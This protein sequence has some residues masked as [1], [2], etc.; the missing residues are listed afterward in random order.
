MSRS[1]RITSFTTAMVLTVM[2]GYGV[3]EL[4]RYY[5]ARTVYLPR[6]Q[7][8][9][10][11]LLSDNFFVCV[12]AGDFPAGNRIPVTHWVKQTNGLSSCE[13]SEADSECIHCDAFKAAGLI[14][15]N[16]EYRFDTGQRT[17]VYHLSELGKK[18]YFANY[19]DRTPG[20]EI[21]CFPGQVRYISS[22]SESDNSHRPGFC[23]AKG[24]RVLPIKEFAGPGYLDGMQQITVRIQ[25]EP[26]DPEPPLFH[27][28]IIKLLPRPLTSINPP[29]F[30]P[31]L[32]TAAF[33]SDMKS[34]EGFNDDLRYGYWPPEQQ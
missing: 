25:L 23:L 31:G 5:V 19:L 18:L 13:R 9:Y 24:V 29:L 34:I 28:E 8:A 10:D 17:T 20:H 11:S 32:T 30:K 33:S 22:D 1:P 4:W 27:P 6:I 14:T 26:I 16:E 21:G 2:A 12:S 15:E 7:A 3:W